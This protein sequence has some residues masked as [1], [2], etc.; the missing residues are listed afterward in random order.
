VTT[1]IDVDLLTRYGDVHEERLAAKYAMEELQKTE[2]ALEDMVIATLQGAGG[3]KHSDGKGRTIHLKR[4]LTCSAIEGPDGA[5]NE[6]ALSIALTGLGLEDMIKSSAN[7]R[8]LA[9]YIREELEAEREIPV[10]LTNVLNIND[11]QRVGVRTSG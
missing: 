6:E 7:K 4:Q 1:Q 11:R 2:T 5:R 9:A 8:T 3:F 10:A